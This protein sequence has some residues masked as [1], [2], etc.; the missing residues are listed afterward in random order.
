MKLNYNFVVP[1]NCHSLIFFGRVF[2]LLW[3]IFSD[4]KFGRNFFS[5]SFSSLQWQAGS[6]QHAVSSGF[7]PD[8][9]SWGWNWLERWMAVR[10]WENR[11]LDINMRDGVNVDGEDAMDGKNGIR[12]QLQSANPQSILL[13]VHPNVASQKT[14][15][16]LSDGCDS[17]SHSN[18]AGLLETSN[19]KSVKPKSN[20]KVPNP[21]EETKSKSE[22]QRSQSNPKERISLVDRQAKKRLSLPNYGKFVLFLCIC[23]M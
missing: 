2:F 6:R 3:F 16:S 13:N 17:S 5:F 14:G 23:L 12:P 1:F 19:T 9:S 8:K 4:H 10:P 18:S 11:F 15:P 22:N 20:A 7:E 21:I